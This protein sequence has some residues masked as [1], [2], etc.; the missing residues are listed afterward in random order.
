MVA[1]DLLDQPLPEIERLRVRVVHAED[2]HPL[3]DPEEEDPL[4][5]I[6]QPLP[7]RGL[8]VERVDV[9][10]FLG[11]VLGVLDA[12]VRAAP[13]PPWVLLHVRVLRRAME[14]DVQRD[15][16]P[17]PLRRL[18][19]VPEIL[20][21]PHLRVDRLVAAFLRPD[22]PRAARLSGHGGEG[23]VLP[24]AEGAGDRVDRREIEDVEAELLHVP[25]PLLQL[26]EGAVPARLRPPGPGEQLIPAAAAGLLPV[27]G[28]AQLAPVPGGGRSPAGPVHPALQR[29]AVRARLL[30]REARSETVVPQRP[31]RDL[32]P[33]LFPLGAEHQ[34]AGHRVVAVREE[35][36]LHGDL[37]P[38]NPLDREPPAVHLRPDPLD[39]HPL[40]QRATLPS[41]TARTAR[42]TRGTRRS[43][44]RRSPWSG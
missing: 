8:E 15:L 35:V 4:H 12:P 34:G 16:E 19:Q 18:Q 38:G 7:L 25:E 6:P 13:E 23:V 24:L 11:R 33:P 5:L 40:G 36:R 17:H 32:R 26:P 43:P 29:V 20:Q 28:D 41:R 39:H 44:P 30:D 9:L 14:G 31:Q 22:R 1:L 10:V 21:R 2:P 3:P 27:H 42:R 37:L